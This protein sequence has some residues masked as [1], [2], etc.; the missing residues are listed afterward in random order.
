MKIEI[1]NDEIRFIHKKY[2]TIFTKIESLIVNLKNIKNN[3]YYNMV[4]LE[5]DS[6]S[7]LNLIFKKNTLLK[8]RVFISSDNKIYFQ[9]D[10]KFKIKN[11]EIVCE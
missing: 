7:K 9:T 1:V 8:Y 3:T 11:N 10:M 2:K 4:L 5:E 6:N